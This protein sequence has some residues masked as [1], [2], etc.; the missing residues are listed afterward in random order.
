MSIVTSVHI[1]GF[2]FLAYS[3]N[4]CSNIRIIVVGGDCRHGGRIVKCGEA[5]GGY[6]P[7]VVDQQ[8]ERYLRIFGAVEIAGTKWCGKTWT[9]RQH[10]A[11]ITYVDRAGNLAAAQ[12]DPSL[13]VL[14]KQPH[15]IDEWQLVRDRRLDQRS[16]S[17]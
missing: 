9:A 13:M 17:Q 15:V 5:N 1:F 2:M 16:Q 8:I 4:D 7:R 11:S 14:G 3:E 10:G 12:A 6:L